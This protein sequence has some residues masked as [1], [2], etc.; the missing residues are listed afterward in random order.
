YPETI[1][2][3]T[4]EI[5]VGEIRA[6]SSMARSAATLRDVLRARFPGTPVQ[7]QIQTLTEQVQRTLIQE[8]MLAALGACFGVLALILA[9]VGLYGLLAY[10]VAR[11]TNEIGMRMALG[12]GRREGL[13][14]VLGTAGGRCGLGVQVVYT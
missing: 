11:S 9:A 14:L 4:F 13:R 5:R 8:R 2:I 7:S 1:A 12:A 3:A 6:G 10:T